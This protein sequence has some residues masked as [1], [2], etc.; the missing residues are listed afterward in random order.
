MSRHGPRQGEKKHNVLELPNAGERTGK[1]GSWS[2]KV[3]EV[4]ILG[5]KNIKGMCIRKGLCSDGQGQESTKNKSE[6]QNGEMPA[7]R[8]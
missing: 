7:S 3:R 8:E 2:L 5:G 4:Y 1:T 6:K